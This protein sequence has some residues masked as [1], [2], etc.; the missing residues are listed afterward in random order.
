MLDVRKP[1]PLRAPALDALQSAGIRH[2]YFTRT[3]GVSDGIYGSLNIGTGS[4]DDPDKVRENR[5]RVATWM[6]VAPWVTNG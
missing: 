4:H 6:G 1:D 3:G 2:G 5:R